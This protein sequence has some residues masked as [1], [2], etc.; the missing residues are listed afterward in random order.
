MNTDI[1]RAYIGLPGTGKTTAQQED[2]T[3]E[4][5]QGTPK[6]NVCVSTYRN[7]MAD[8][9]KQRAEKEHGDLPDENWFGTTHSICFQLLGLSRERTADDA[10]KAEFC[11]EFGVEFNGGS[12]GVAD[13]LSSISGGNAVGDDLFQLR[14]HCINTKR[15]PAT[16]WRPVL[17]P[18]NHGDLLSPPNLIE[19]FNREWERYKRERGLFDFDDMLVETIDRGLVPDADVLF[20]D[21]FQDKSPL[22]VDL[23]EQWADHI[24]RVYVAGDPF[25]AIYGHVGTDPTFMEEAYEIADEQVFLDKSYRFGPELWETALQFLKRSRQGPEQEIEPVGESEVHRIPQSQFEYQA[26]ALRDEEVMYLVRCNYHASP[27]ARTLN[28][29]GIVYNTTGGPRWSS[30]MINLYNGTVKVQRGLKRLRESEFGY[31]VDWSALTVEEIHQ[32]VKHL[33]A[34][35]QVGTKKK[36]IDRTDPE[37]P[38]LERSDLDVRELVDMKSVADDWMGTNPWKSGAWTGDRRPEGDVGKRL[39]QA[40]DVRDGEVIDEITHSIQTIHTAKGQEADHV[41]LFDGISQ[42]I[43]DACNPFPHADDDEARVW[44]VAATRARKHLW[45]VET[46]N[47]PTFNFPRV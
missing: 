8:E 22:Q 47:N 21:E 23:F 37:D 7:S 38:E 31:G 6:E 27:I 42:G 36:N 40:Y 35:R 20:E 19:D 28:D 34:T 18:I 17:D 13:G 39:S 33:R 4:L 45:L 2:L 29:H 32:L 43:V 12:G 46:D 44:F 9:F 14:S 15:D 11:D 30:D 16:E 24:D 3:T 5:D 1:Y 26:P 10:V 41:F 25:Q